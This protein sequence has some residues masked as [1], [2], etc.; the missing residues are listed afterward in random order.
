MCELHVL[1]VFVNE[2]GECGN[3]LGV[4]LASPWHSAAERQRV[5][6]R[7]GFS[8]TVFVQDREQASIRI[9]TPQLE[10]P[11]AGHP[12][13]GVAWLLA[14][15]G[16]AAGILRPPAGEVEA[17][18][19]LDRAQVTARPSWAPAFDYRRLE[20]PAEVGSLNPADAERNV[21]AWAW[22]D[23][24]AGTIRARSFVPEAGIVEDEAT[25]SAALALC[26]Q[27]GRAVTIHQ[28][29]GSVIEARP[30]GDDLAEVGG[31]VALDEVRPFGVR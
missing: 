29:R 9:H 8:E 22:I 20:S 27:L 2:N 13:I 12:L 3:P 21:Y 5:A 15:T 30:L 7:L 23:E 28:G 16:K 19:A 4:F 6:Q 24:S 10:L 1:R 18:V 11:F 26:R 14:K 17:R 31:R 25:G